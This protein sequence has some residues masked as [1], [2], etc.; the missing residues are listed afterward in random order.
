MGSCWP[1]SYTHA[2][3]PR[4]GTRELQNYLLASIHCRIICLGHARLA[5]L[6]SLTLSSRTGEDVGRN[7]RNKQNEFRSASANAMGGSGIKVD[8]AWADSLP[9]PFPPSALREFLIA[10]D[11]DEGG[12]PEPWHLER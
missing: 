6:G 11:P 4:P 2:P 7:K 12:F 8:T 9:Q 1:L 3:F 10:K 5:L